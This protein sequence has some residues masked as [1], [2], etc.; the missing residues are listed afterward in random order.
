MITR[1]ELLHNF[2]IAKMNLARAK[3]TELRW[4]VL[5]AL[6]CFPGEIK[7]GTNWSDDGAVKLINKVTVSLDKD[8][9]KVQ[10][11][12]SQL[13]AAYPDATDAHNLV[14]WEYKFDVT[15][16]HLQPDE[17]KTILAPLLTIKPALP[18][19]TLASDPDESV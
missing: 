3:A 4:R 2:A 9:A 8:K 7:L 10:A 12:M 16:Y 1:A 6:H 19:V 15:A 5:V 13:V 14:T 18:T 11:V 17:I